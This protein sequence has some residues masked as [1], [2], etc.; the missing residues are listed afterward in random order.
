MFSRVTTMTTTQT[1][2]SKCGGRLDT[3][4]RFCAHCGAVQDDAA[5]LPVMEAA[6]SVWDGVLAHLR[7]VIGAKYEIDRALG[8]GGMAAVFLAREIRLNRRVA[9]KVM[10]PSLMLSP[11]MIERFHREAVT[12]AALN[13]SNIVTIYTV[14]ETDKVLYF[15]MKYVPGP[16]LE[17]VISKDGPLPISVVRVWLTQIASALGYAHRRGVVHRDIKP[18]NILL[19]DE[20]NAIVTDFGIA[21]VAREPSL[22]QVGATVGTPA[23]MS[24]EQCQ[25]KEISAASDQYSLGIV[26]YEML[27]GEPPFNGPSLEVMQAH[28]QQ[29]ARP[30]SVAR[31]DCPR[32]LQAAI[33]RMITKDA[34]ERWPS[35]EEIVATVG[36]SPLSLDDPIRQQ[37]AELAGTRDA[38]TVIPIPSRPPVSKATPGRVASLEIRPAHRVVR[39]GRAARF[40]AV[41][42]GSDGAVLRNR[43][44]SWTS[45]EPEVAAVSPDG[46]A[47]GLLPGSASITA[48]CEGVSGSAEVEV[49]TQAA[50]DRVRALWWILPL[51]ALGVSGAWYVAQQLIGDRP[52]TIAAVAVIPATA[53]VTVGGTAALAA[54]AEDADGGALAAGPVEWTSS[55][56]AVAA[57]TNDGRVT[58]VKPG[59][60]TITATVSSGQT[61]SSRITVMPPTPR[62][63]TNVVAIA[64]VPRQV[65]LAAAQTFTLQAIAKDARGRTVRRPVLWASSNPAVATVSRTGVLTGVAPGTANVT[66]MSE[67]ARSTPTAVTVI[68]AGPAILEM[69]VMPW[70]YVS[71]NGLPRGQRTRGADT[72]PPGVVHRVHFERDGFISF[73]TTV[74]LRPGDRL[75]LT[76]QMRPR[77]P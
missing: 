47:R 52:P 11:G 73:D 14:E 22:T 23:Y 46:A 29:R 40:Q 24:P 45:S 18:A 50:L 48:A 19:D 66:A 31:P 70:A 4:D 41:A 17:S 12:V 21:K 35:M 37:L 63:D 28:V 43:E 71:I 9:I 42:R 53:S 34:S 27:T 72:L 58:G 7:T 32:D 6:D 15:V 57:V 74:T 3:G 75:R 56:S 26:L 16:S 1:T 51:I 33:L 68:P 60:A 64:I 62:V 49:R 39:V 59:E 44:V 55:D 65:R 2:C 54:T 13:H 69:V 36:G 77:N 10:S 20:G 25:S 8:Y 30:I 67:A 38:I 76:H 5:T 61:G